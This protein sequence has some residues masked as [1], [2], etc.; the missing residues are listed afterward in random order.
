MISRKLIVIID[1]DGEVI[2]LAK[3]IF[4][5]EREFNFVHAS[6]E[7]LDMKE[8]LDTI[9]D[10]III[11]GDNLKNDLFHVCEI[12]R[13]DKDNSI[14]PVIVTSKNKDE[15][16]RIKVL[17]KSIEY[18]IPKPL[19]K[20][21]FYYTIKNLARLIYSN[22]GSSPL[23]GLPGNVQIEAELKRRI[24]SKKPYA[25]IYMDLDNFKAYNDSYGFMNGDEV[26][27]YT[28]SVIQDSIEKYGGRNDFIG[29][30]GGDDFV[31]VVDYENARK[32]STDIV[33]S[34]DKGIVEFFNEEDLKKGGIELPNRKGKIEK[35][36]ITSISVAMISNKY[37]KY[38]TPLEIGEDGALVK[39]KAKAIEGS[40]F[41]EDRRRTTAK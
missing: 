13:R 23:T 19:H 18:Y 31:A 38:K 25:V 41:I 30:I 28:S 16:F 8:A 37:K 29:H 40:T 6:S 12:I 33:K 17:K 3:T 14:T 7:K 1:D 9:P 35:F 39:K 36:P 2:N 5:H 21:F 34:F 15:E 11:N 4:T 24:A 26:I 32:I 27:K 10:L 22:R 20:G